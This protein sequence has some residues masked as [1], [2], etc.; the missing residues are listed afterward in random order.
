M[1]KKRY[2]IDVFKSQR[3]T[4]LKALDKRIE[5]DLAGIKIIDDKPRKIT[6]KQWKFLESLTP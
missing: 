6:K 4:Y 2:F 1:K 3:E 5:K